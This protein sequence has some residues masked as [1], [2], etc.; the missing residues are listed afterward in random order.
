MGR[1]TDSSYVVTVAT[2]LAVAVGCSQPPQT[3]GGTTRSVGSVIAPPPPDTT[4]PMARD[5]TPDARPQLARLEQQARALARTDGCA[6]VGAC[7]TAPVGWRGCG[8][9]RTYLVYCAATTDTVALF[10]KLKELETAERNYNASSSMMS[11][12]EFRLA[13]A[14]RLEG[15]SCRERAASP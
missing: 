15:R 11:T 1:L 7:R 9:P 14:V 6:S 4:T 3:G 5:T 8:G 12:C 13:P 10:R 2:V